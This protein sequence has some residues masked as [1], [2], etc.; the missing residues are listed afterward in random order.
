M[1]SWSKIDFVV[2]SIRSGR[3]VR[4]VIVFVAA[5][6]VVVVVIKDVIVVGTVSFSASSSTWLQGCC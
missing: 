4:M 2:F 1:K 6:V 3:K 5:V